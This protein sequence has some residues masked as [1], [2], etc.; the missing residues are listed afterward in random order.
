MYRN[1]SGPPYV[2]VGILEVD[3]SSE[4]SMV[5]VPSS[6]ARSPLSLRCRSRLEDTRRG[7]RALPVRGSRDICCFSDSR[8]RF[9]PL[10]CHCFTV[11]QAEKRVHQRCS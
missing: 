7:G 4:N 9:R 2:R 6:S 8:V 3:Q 10:G 1:V 11:E 5:D